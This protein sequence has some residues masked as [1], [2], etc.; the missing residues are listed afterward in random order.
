MFSF[1]FNYHIEMVSG[2]QHCVKFDFSW[3]VTLDFDCYYIIR[4]IICNYDT[5]LWNL[6]HLLQAGQYTSNWWKHFRTNLKIN[7]PS[8]DKWT[9][10]SNKSLLIWNSLYHFIAC[11]HTKTVLALLPMQMFKAQQNLFLGFYRLVKSIYRNKGW[12]FLTSMN[13]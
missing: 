2:Y 7:L 9:A 13:R 3:N 5:W 6:M 10:K 12:Y 8:N 11:L 1:H 4:W